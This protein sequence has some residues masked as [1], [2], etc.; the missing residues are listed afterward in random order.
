MT[1]RMLST[2]W[3]GLAA[4][5]LFASGCTST[6]I[7][8]HEIV[9]GPVVTVPAISIATT[10]AQCPPSKVALSAGFI[11]G[12]GSDPDTRFGLEMRGAIPDERLGT[13]LMRNANLF[14]AATAQAIAVCVQAPVGLRV[15]EALGGCADN[16]RL[17]GGGYMGDEA[18]WVADNGPKRLPTGKIDWGMHIAEFRTTGVDGDPPPSSRPGW[19]G[20]CAPATSVDGW[21]FVD[22][23][24]VSLGR[25]AAAPLTQVCPIGKVLLGAGVTLQGGDQL[26]L[27]TS[28]LRLSDNQVT[29]QVLNRNVLGT[30]GPVSAVLGVLCAK[31]Q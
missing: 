29:A 31:P 16:E 27:V 4:L 20:L 14:V 21:E 30:S 9:F 19:R 8:G 5:C 10:S 7:I 17:V 6:G 15:I 23:A 2:T 24:P 25:R 22:S 26:D 13:V 18:T 28:S 3:F 1:I 11:F 12:A